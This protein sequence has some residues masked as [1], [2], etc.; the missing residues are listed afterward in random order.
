MNEIRLILKTAA[1]RLEMTSFIGWVHLLTVLFGCAVLCLL[2]AERIGE[3]TFLPWTWMLPAIVAIGLLIAGRIWFIRRNSEL[4]VALEVDERLDLHE[5]L[6]T[7]LHCSGRDDA[8]ARTALDDALQT[9]RDARTRE[10]VNRHFSVEAPRRWW[11]SPMIVAL[12]AALWFVPA[13]DLFAA[14]EDQLTQEEVIANQAPK[15]A[16]EAVV[17]SIKESPEL[18]KELSDMLGDLSK[19]G[20]DPDAPRS[21]EDSKRIALK[22]LTEL[23]KRLDDILNGSKGKTADALKKSLRQLKTPESGPAKELA[24]ALSRGDFAQAKKA[25]QKL[26]DDAKKGNLNKQQQEQ[27]AKQLEDLAKQMEKLAQQQQQMEQLLKQAGMNPQLA[28]NPQALQKAIQ[29]N[30]NLNQQQKQ[31]LQQMAQAQQAAAQACQGMGQAMQQM[32]QAMKQGQNGQQAGQQ[33]ANQLNQLEAMQQMLMQAQAAANACKGGQCQG[34]GMQQAWQQW[35]TQNKGGAFGNRG[36]SSGGG[37]APIKKTPSGTKVQQAKSKT[38]QGDI[39][40]RWLV[41]G[42]NYQGESTAKL[43]QVQAA[44]DEGYEEGISEDEI[45]IRY[46]EAQKH[47][48]GELQDSIKAARKAG[49]ESSEADKST[50]NKTN[51]ES[52]D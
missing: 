1:R 17:K 41:E 22:N 47:Y 3:Q 44:I 11:L 4:Q 15:D 40:A 16:V 30:A 6:S 7:A 38:T 23:N 33:M 51:S 34:L 35:Q 12:A 25:L 27:V 18:Q 20:I 24:D 26:L 19:E 50:E 43:Q 37:K 29:N 21:R 2:I 5:K 9:A 45:P 8:F 10:A 42:P 31:Q 32:A 13:L 46:R 28:Q 49:K 52:D 36:Q 14:D 48:F 39:I